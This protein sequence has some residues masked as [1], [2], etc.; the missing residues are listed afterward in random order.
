[1]IKNKTSISGTTHCGLVRK[2]NEDAFLYTNY[3][4]HAANLAVVAD[5][6]GGHSGGDIASFLV[7]RTLFDLWQKEKAFRMDRLGKML[8]FMRDSLQAINHKIHKRNIFEKREKPMGCTVVAAVF[9]P[10]EVVILHA[11]D[12]RLYEFTADQKLILHTEDQTLW[13]RV[14]KSKNLP[15]HAPV[16]PQYANIILNAIG[17]R[18][19]FVPCEYVLPYHDDSVYLLC[20]DGLSHLVSDRDIARILSENPNVSEAVNQLVRAAYIAGADDNLSII[21]KGKKECHTLI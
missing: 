16:P 13:E 10:A 2:Q 18:G 17:I 11:G 8:W 12:S 3:P 7:C 5:G 15:V 6:I 21:L 20:S 1:M 19:K 14:R 9:L 4:E